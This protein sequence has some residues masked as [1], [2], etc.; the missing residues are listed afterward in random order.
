MKLYIVIVSCIWLLEVH[1]LE[2]ERFDA[3]N[4]TYIIMLKNW[5]VQSKP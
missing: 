5:W 2:F 1:G 4:K 3:F